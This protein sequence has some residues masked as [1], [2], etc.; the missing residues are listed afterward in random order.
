M[1]LPTMSNC[2][3]SHCIE[4]AHCWLSNLQTGSAQGKTWYSSYRQRLRCPVKLARLSFS[5]LQTRKGRT[6]RAE[7]SENPAGA[8]RWSQQHALTVLLQPYAYRLAGS[9]ERDEPR[10]LDAS[11]SETAAISL[12][13]VPGTRSSRSHVFLGGR[14]ISIADRHVR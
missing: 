5:F 4:L 8:A 7:V 14:C 9:Q 10:W 2:E 12:L 13:V 3:S 6:Y 1:T 11:Q